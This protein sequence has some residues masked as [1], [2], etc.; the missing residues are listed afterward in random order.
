[1]GPYHLEEGKNRL[2]SSNLEDC[3][4]DGK[5]FIPRSNVAGGQKRRSQSAVESNPGPGQGTGST[6]NGAPARPGDMFELMVCLAPEG[7]APKC[8]LFSP[9]SNQ[10]ESASHSQMQRRKKLN[11]DQ[12]SEAGTSTTSVNSPS[13]SEWGNKLAGGSS[14]DS[15]ANTCTIDLDSSQSI[16]GKRRKKPTTPETAVNSLKSTS[17]SV[18]SDETMPT[19]KTQ[20]R[21]VAI[22]TADPDLSKSSN[23]ICEVSYIRVSVPKSKEVI[24]PVESVQ[25]MAAVDCQYNVINRT[26]SESANAVES[27]CPSSSTAPKLLDIK[28]I[29]QRVQMASGVFLTQ[30]IYGMDRNRIEEDPTPVTDEED[31]TSDSPLEAEREGTSTAPV[32]SIPPGITLDSDAI[33]CVICLT[34]NRTIAVYPCRHMCLCASCAEVLP[35]QVALNS[36]SETKFIILPYIYPLFI[37]LPTL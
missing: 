11:P 3:C 16:E 4:I 7:M 1:M 10:V 33:E 25:N 31:L 5:Y 29:M 27:G 12:Q 30:D 2:W 36:S 37:F 9:V 6:G 14:K 35:S 13:S 28:C 23:V 17:V 21:H 22:H 19:G 18:G 26:P 20:S 34:D 8:G 24:T 32:T 15:T